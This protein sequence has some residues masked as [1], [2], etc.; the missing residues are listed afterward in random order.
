MY[1]NEGCRRSVPP[2]ARLARKCWE[3]RVCVGFAAGR[4]RMS[5]GRFRVDGVREFGETKE[6]ENAQRVIGEDR[7]RLILLPRTAG[8]R[9]TLG[10]APA[11]PPLTDF[12]YF[13]FYSLQ[14]WACCNR[15]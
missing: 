1:Q 2:D 7:E 8:P 9:Q 10:G 11:G 13:A 15:R 4:G 12:K 6:F 5:V 3:Y 14:G